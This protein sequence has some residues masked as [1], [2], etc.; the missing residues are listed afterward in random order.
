MNTLKRKL[1][2]ILLTFAMLLS[3]MPAFPQAAE[4]ATTVVSKNGYV[5]V[6]YTDEIAGNE[7]F[8]VNVYLDGTIVDTVDITDRQNAS[9]NITVKVNNDQYEIAGRAG[10][11]TDVEGLGATPKPDVD[12]SLQSVSCLWTPVVNDHLT[13]NV[14]LRSD[15]MERPTVT[16]NGIYEED[17]ATIGYRFYDS[18]IFKMLALAERDVPA[19][20]KIEKVQINFISDTSLGGTVTLTDINRVNDYWYTNEILNVNMKASPNN[21][22]NLVITYG[23]GQ[24]LTIPAGDLLIDWHSG[25]GQYYSVESNNTESHIVW[26]YNE[27]NS[28]TVNDFY[29]YDYRIVRDGECLGEDY[30]PTPPTYDGTWNEYQFVNWE[31]DTWT[32]DGATGEAFLPTTIVDKD[33]TVYAHKVSSAKG[34]TWIDVRNDD[35]RFLERVVELYNEANDVDITVSDIKTSD[36]DG[37]GISVYD[38]NDNK[39]QPRYLDSGWKD[40]NTY[41]RVDN[42]DADNPS[43]GSEWYNNKLAFDEVD[44]IY[45]YFKVDGSEEVNT[46][47]IPVGNNDGDLAKLMGDAD[48]ILSLY[49]IQDDQVINDGSEDPD[50]EPDP[51]DLNGTDVTVQVVVDGTPVKNPLSYVTLSRDTTETDYDQF[52]Q[53]NIDDNGVITYDFNY[54]VP[55]SP[56]DTSTGYDCVDIEVALNNDKSA[57]ILQGVTSYQTHGQN[58]TSNVDDNSDD[59][60]N[61]RNTFTVDNVTSDKNNETVDCIIY[62]RSKYSVEYYLNDVLQTGDAYN[63]GTIYLSDED[64]TTT[65]AEKNYP[66]DQTAKLMYWQNNANY[67]TGID[68]LPEF[69]KDGDKVVRGWFLGSKSNQTTTY[70][71][72]KLFDAIDQASDTAASTTEDHV[73]QF[74]ATSVDKTQQYPLTYDANG[75]ENA[76]A[77]SIHEENSQVTLSTDYP[78]HE[79]VNNIPVVIVGWSETDTDEKIYAADEKNELPKI[80]TAVLMDKDRTVYAVWGYDTNGNDVPDVNE[81][82]YDLIYDANGGTIEDSK[83]NKAYV[84]ELLPNKYTVWAR[85]DNGNFTGTYPKDA[86]WPMHESVKGDNVILIGW[87]AEPDTKI[88]TDADDEKVVRDKLLSEIKI[89]ANSVTVYALWGLDDNNNG[90][91]DVFENLY[92]LTYDANGGTLGNNGPASIE[93][94]DLTTGE[95]T[96]WPADNASGDVVPK[97]S[98]GEELGEPVHADAE[99]PADSV[100]SDEGATVGVAFIGWSTTKPEKE[101]FAAGEN[102]GDIVSKVTIPNSTNPANVT[103]YAVWGYD[104]NGDGV[105]DAQ[106][107][108]ITPADI[109]IYEGGEGYEGVLETDNGEMVGED[110]DG[111]GLPEPGYY[112]ILPYQ[113]DNELGGADTIVN[114]EGQLHLAYTNQDNPND[115]RSWNV[116]LYN[117]NDPEASKAYGRYVYRLVPET[118]G[119]PVR[120]EIKDGEQLVS[121]DEFEISLNELSQTYSMKLYTDPQV[122]RVQVTAQIKDDSDAW[123]D[124]NEALDADVVEGIARGTASL[125]IRGTTDENPVSAIQDTVTDE[126]ETITAVQPNNVEYLI[127]DSDIP[128]IMNAEGNNV[129][130][131]NDTIVDEDG[132][133]EAMEEAIVEAAAND[134]DVNIDADYTF[135]FRYLD[136]V[137]TD[138]GNAYVTMAD[139]QEMTIYWPYPEDMDQDDTFYVAHFDGLDRD[140]TAGELASAINDADLKLYSEGDANYKLETTENGIKFTTSTF[141]PFA[142]VYDASQADNGGNQG[143]GGWTPDGG[144]DGPDGLNTEDHFSYIVGYAEDYRTGEPTDNEDLWPVKPNNQ[145]TRA[146]VATIFYRLLEDEVRDEYDTTANDFSDVSADSWYNQTVSTL[147]SMGILKGYEDGTFRPNASITRAEFAA[148]ATRFF[149]ETGATYEPGTFTDVT[150]DEW[151]AGAIMDAVNLGLI[152]GYEDGTVRPNN[153]ITRAEAC[154]IVNRTLGRVPDADHLLPAD[155]MTTWPDNPSSAWFYADMQEATNG[156]EYEWITEDGNKIEEWTDIL[157]KD[158]NDR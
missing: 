27:K 59:E 7:H 47:Q 85:D 24:T 76:P 15:K 14:T 52:I 103:V 146:E 43:S 83:E 56:D 32:G 18:Q 79:N 95:K 140:F 130:L 11:S 115:Q 10:V 151:F 108:V 119:Y 28:T 143:G 122:D 31:I 116:A 39:S 53:R 145:I 57:Y 101:I 34:G 139:G 120:L 49:V 106:Q 147:A 68:S 156:H 148:I 126:V 19:D 84:T 22:E 109:V 129:Q 77:A 73:I 138:N 94:K 149:D 105:A 113:L 81:N 127:N 66:Q 8:T 58:G 150:G 25:A 55:S 118:D 98:Q 124:V 87:T 61:A 44:G 123:V 64:V 16:D 78:T 157:D 141:S 65:T 3:L 97:D 21:I 136:L 75:G 131:L 36:K 132:S 26:F 29:P 60:E 30:M 51:D 89:E 121:S 128:V 69:P 158:W 102:Y 9:G 2:A 40:D 155:E 80:T 144:D 90:T 104:E 23:G 86:E 63:V 46:V 96:L 33:M 6:E 117:E 154:A 35:N 48:T 153:N 91:P 125:T 137:D 114:L 135:D 12:M 133:Q 70:E 99:A 20:T 71:P 82:L 88:Y 112:F 67:E 42:Y 100:I 37:F 1:T 13:I 111:N 152:G 54:F 5:A 107:I 41:Y 142:L 93:I 134:E 110:A 72:E 92:T 45:V 4:A 17:D 62:L 50:P 38:I 74:Y